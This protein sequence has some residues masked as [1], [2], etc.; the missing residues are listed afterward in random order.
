M[1]NQKLFMRVL[2]I[3]ALINGGCI[4]GKTY[5]F[6]VD[7]VSLKY[8][9][10]LLA[11]EA[12]EWRSDAY[13]EWASID[14]GDSD[15]IVSA[16]FQSPSEEFE[17]VLLVYD[18]KTQEIREEI[19]PHEVSINYHV[20]IEESD[21][22]LDSDEA[23][24]AFFSYED[25][26]KAWRQTPEFCNALKLRHFYVDEQWVLAWVLTVSDCSSYAEY[27]YLDPITGDRLELDY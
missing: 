5:N 21:W 10:D 15:Q 1:N 27:F 17:S 6:T 16:S 11:K 18:P 20:P 14:F 19:I 7:I 24:E 12:E 9:Y 26:Q 3:L 22:E 8:C 25:I 4:V 2:I 23:I 13:L